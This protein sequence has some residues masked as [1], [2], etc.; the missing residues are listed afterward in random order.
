MN[1]FVTLA[2]VSTLALSGASHAFGQDR[3]PGE[4]EIAK[5]PPGLSCPLGEVMGLVNAVFLFALEEARLCGSFARKRSGPIM[6]VFVD[7]TN[8]YA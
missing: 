4:A 6:L 5:L 8:L 3:K 1:R 7:C 2:L